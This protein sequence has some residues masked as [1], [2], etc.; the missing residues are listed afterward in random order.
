MREIDSSG[1]KLCAIQGE[2]FKL[3]LHNIPYGSAIFIRRFMNSKVCERIDNGGFL[4]E[5]C[6]SLQVL[7][8]IT[9]EYGTT[10]YGKQKYSEDE[11]YWIGYIY[12]Y[13]AY[14]QEKSSKM[15]F[16]I[17]G[18]REMRSLFFPYHSLDPQQAIER[19]MEAKGV[20]NDDMITR[21]VKI[22]RR[23]MNSKKEG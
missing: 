5:A 12:R 18:A 14:T 8:E 16:K 15:L 23:V 7:D 9:A 3:S 17:I 4:F 13:W 11:L 1:L 20:D 6:D 10:E 21:G 22:L 19:I 2:V